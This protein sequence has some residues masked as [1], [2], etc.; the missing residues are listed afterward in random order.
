MT[1]HIYSPDDIRHEQTTPDSVV[2]PEKIIKVIEGRAIPKTEANQNTDDMVYGEFLNEVSFAE[3]A[4][5]LFYNERFNSDRKPI[6]DHPFNNP[7]YK[8]AKI[9]F[10]GKNF[11]TGS[12][13]E[14]AVQS[15]K[16]YGIGALVAADYA[17]I[18]QGNCAEVGLVAVTMP[19]EEIEELAKIVRNDSQM[20][21]RLDLEDMKIKYSYMVVGYGPNK[22]TGFKEVQIKMPEAIR[23]SFLTGT[24]DTLPLLQ[25]NQDAIDAYLKQAPFAKFR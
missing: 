7:V 6:Q 25:R 8:G 12:S 19:M 2:V 24:W 15:L 1:V 5:Y 21:F 23:Q 16:K 3:M 9:L 17:G 10:G 22:A 13:R 20:R 11:G 4:K 14:H 18:F